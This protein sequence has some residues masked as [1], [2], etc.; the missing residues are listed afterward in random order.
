P[1][2]WDF[3]SRVDFVDKL[4][5]KNYQWDTAVNIARYFFFK[6]DYDYY[7]YST[8]D[9]IGYPDH[10]KMLIQDT[11]E[12]G[13]PIISGWC[14]SIAYLAALSINPID[15]EILKN[16]LEKPFPGLTYENYNF[17]SVKDVATGAYGFPFVK[18]WFNGGPLMLFTRDALRELPWRGWRNCRDKY[19]IT[20]DAKKRGRPVMADITFAIDCVEKGI[21]LMTDLRVF[22]YHIFST[23]GNLRVGRDNPKMSFIAAKT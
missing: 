23:S 22:L 5:V 4:I 3:V 1:V 11:E 8:D 6:Q 14:N 13:F 20:P 7:I 21:P 10:L 9:V 2:F 12:H 17:L 16:S 19:C 18:V 15:E